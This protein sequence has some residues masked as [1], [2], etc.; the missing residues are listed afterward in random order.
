MSSS[1]VASQTPL[2]RPQMAIS[3]AE[4]EEALGHRLAEPGAAAGDEDF[5]A[6]KQAV[7]E[8][9]R[10]LPDSTLGIGGRIEG[11]GVTRTRLRAV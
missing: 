5:F 3:A 11:Y 1:A 7:D 4:A 8:H 10:S 2:R 9:G 6:R